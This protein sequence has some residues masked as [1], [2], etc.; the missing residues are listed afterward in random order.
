MD[1]T[2]FQLYSLEII[3]KYI[4]HYF[5]VHSKDRVFYVVTG[6]INNYST[7]FLINLN[8]SF[9]GKQFQCLKMNEISKDIQIMPLIL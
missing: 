6:V 8:Y 4:I 3:D 5:L 1:I 9:S 7:F 2:R